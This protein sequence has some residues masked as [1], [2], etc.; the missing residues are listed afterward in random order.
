MVNYLAVDFGTTK[1]VQQER[2]EGNSTTI[3]I[4]QND[5][6]PSDVFLGDQIYVGRQARKMG[7][8]DP[9]RLVTNSRDDRKNDK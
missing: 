5:L 6:N 8:K 4:E 7:E 3:Q 1:L 9:S 2:Y